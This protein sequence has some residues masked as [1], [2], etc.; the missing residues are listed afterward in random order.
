MKTTIIAVAFAVLANLLWMAP[1][2]A[3]EVGF[4]RLTVPDPMGGEMQVSVWYPARE[5]ASRVKLGPYTFEA[6]R[7]AEPQVGLHPLVVLSHGTEGSDLGHRNVAI[8]LAQQGIIAA[9]PL[10]PRDNFKDNSGVG[11]RIV[12]E[13]RPR[14]LTAVID[15]LVSHDLWSTRVDALRI[16]AFGFSLGGYTVLAALGAQPDMM[17]IAAHCDV[18]NTDPF[19][20]IAGSQEGSLRPHIEREFPTPLT[21]LADSRLCAASII[22]PVAI[23]FADAAL[24]AIP[25]RQLQLWRPE[26][27]NVLSAQAHASRVVAQLN[28]RQG[29]EITAEIVVKGAQHYSF[30]APFPW[31]LKWV[32]PSELTQDVAAFDRDAFQKDF[33]EEVSSFLVKALQ[34]CTNVD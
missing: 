20:T 29:V 12:M 16:G 19:C 6:A 22:D 13:G 31:R 17:R 14:Q 7:D 34:A 11:R 2:R 5:P 18:P 21:G 15:A 23:P 1:T 9:A 32:L 30:L 25:A 10:H 33:A 4:T 26:F 24:A 8:A 27:E 28:L 3:G